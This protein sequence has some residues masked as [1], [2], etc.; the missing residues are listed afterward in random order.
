[1]EIRKP[2]KLGNEGIC[3]VGLESG[4]RRY[5]FGTTI[6]Y[7]PFD[8]LDEREFTDM[9]SSCRIH[10]VWN[11]DWRKSRARVGSKSGGNYDDWDVGSSCPPLRFRLRE[12]Q[13][14]GY[15]SKNKG[16]D[17]VSICSVSA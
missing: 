13:I 7:P 14:V 2:I 3:K 17:T 6:R 9:A 8:P 4:G 10:S 16:G 5:P 12:I 15:V 11:A 1:M